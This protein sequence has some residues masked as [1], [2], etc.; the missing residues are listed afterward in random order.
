MPVLFA[1]TV[2][3]DAFYDNVFNPERLSIGEE[4]RMLYSCPPR[5]DL[6]PPEVQRAHTHTISSFTHYSLDKHFAKWCKQGE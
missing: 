4:L 5:N 2:D 3:G 6:K 1:A